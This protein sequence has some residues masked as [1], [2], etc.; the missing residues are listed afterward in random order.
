MSIYSK[1]QWKEF[2]DN[3]IELDGYRCTNCG[4]H[5]NEV[6]LQVH[7][8]KYISGR[9]P[10]EYPTEECRTLCKGCHASEHGMIKPQFGWEYI[11][12]DDLGDL[13]GT[14]EN[15]GSSLRYIFIIHHDSWGTLEVGTYCCDKLTDSNIA[16][17]LMESQTSFRGRKERFLNS[18]RWKYI[19]GILKIRQNLFD[20]EIRQ[21]DMSYYLK[22]H[23]LE[24]KTKYENLNQAKSKAFEVIETGEFMEYLKR[25]NISFDEK[26]KPN[27]K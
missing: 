22:I 23:R 13:I 6:V 24:S 15:C 21:N 7:H 18:S 3:V 19:D 1:S 11:G 5:K 9:K 14:C 17:N 8:K 20:I 12:D 2:R 16:S 26:K 25:N 4:R 27:K 10:W